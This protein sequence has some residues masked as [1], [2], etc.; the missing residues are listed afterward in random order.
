MFMAQVDTADGPLKN[1]NVTTRENTIMKDVSEQHNNF[2][3]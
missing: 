2:P 3:I 1:T